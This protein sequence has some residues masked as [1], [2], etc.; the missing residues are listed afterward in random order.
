MIGMT[1]TDEPSDGPGSAEVV[2]VCR[3]SV[4]E[5]LAMRGT[6]WEAELAA[7]RDRR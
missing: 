5:A 1:T 3:M 7:L 4:Q 2:G 6:G